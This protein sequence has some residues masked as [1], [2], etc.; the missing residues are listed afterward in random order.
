MTP[1][2]FW[3]MSGAGNDF[4]VL[5]P[6][7]VEPPA[8]VWEQVVRRWCT[9]RMSIGADGVIFVEPADDPGA[10]VRVRFFNPDGGEFDTCGNGSRCAARFAFEAGLAP[11]EMKIATG[12]GI[13]S[14]TV[15]GDRVRVGFTEPRRVALDVAVTVDGARRVGH[16]VE[17]GVPHFVLTVEALPEGAIEPEARKLRHASELGPAGANVNYVEVTGPAGL[18]VRT[19]ERGVEAET[20][21]C[22]SGVRLGGGRARRGGPGR[23]ARPGAHA[24]RLAP[25]S[26]LPAGGRPL[27]G[28]LAGGGRADH[29]PGR[30]GT[31][32]DAMGRG[33]GAPVAHLRRRLRIWYRRRKRPLPW[34]ETR[35]PYRVW[36][37]EVMLQQT[38]VETVIPY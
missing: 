16:C 17:F 14:A 28:D 19:Y 7:E 32:R 3:K 1:L 9:R 23:A 4:I 5:N 13:V 38:R 34:R 31:R 15:R 26:V 25:R 21:A 22:G 6:R 10:D 18:A 29:L 12:A 27:H 8:A 20:L 33:A 2:G 37:S 30:A 36:I 11:A 35:D 24:Q